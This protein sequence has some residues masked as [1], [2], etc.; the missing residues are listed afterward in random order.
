MD[1]LNQLPPISSRSFLSTKL[2][3][4]PRL[5]NHTHLADIDPTDGI[6]SFQFG[7]LFCLFFIPF[8]V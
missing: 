3:F 5:Q 7:N 8:A 4:W 6:F 2:A 1:I